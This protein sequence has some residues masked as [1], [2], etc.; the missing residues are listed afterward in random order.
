MGKKILRGIST[1]K[2]YASNH[3]E[4]AEWYTKFWGSVPYFKVVDYEEFCIGGYQ[5]ELGIINSTFSPQNINDK[6]TGATVYWHVDNLQDT[7]DKLQS[8]GAKIFQP[9]AD[10]ENGFSTA[11]L[12]DPFG[13]ILGI[14]T[15]PHY[16]E[17][18]EKVNGD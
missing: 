16:L 14:M 9:I 3:N 5:Q 11:S 13:N 17:I 18:L 1:I 15:N 6:P 4:A 12:V 7:F 2:F 8:L 10:R